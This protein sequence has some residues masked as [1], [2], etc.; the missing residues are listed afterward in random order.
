MNREH[1]VQLPPPRQLPANSVL[2]ITFVLA[3]RRLR[4]GDQ[5]ED[6][7]MSFGATTRLSL[8]YVGIGIAGLPSPRVSQQVAIHFD[9]VLRGVDL[10]AIHELVARIKLQ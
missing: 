6:V 10:E 5:I 9:H 7:R 4:N 3:E 8:K 2:Q 1:S